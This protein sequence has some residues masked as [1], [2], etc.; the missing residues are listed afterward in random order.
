MALQRANAVSQVINLLIMA[1]GRDL[2]SLIGLCIVMVIQDPVMSLAGFIVTPPAF[3]FLR[4][5]TTWRCCSARLHR[6]PSRRN[7]HP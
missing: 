4:K 1:I 5:R 3:L 2:M 7:V 6:K